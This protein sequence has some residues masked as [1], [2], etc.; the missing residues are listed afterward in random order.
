[1]ADE[2]DAQPMPQVPQPAHT[3]IAG[4]RHIQLTADNIFID[5]EPALT[6]PAELEYARAYLAG[7]LAHLNAG[8]RRR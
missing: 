3:I 2:P 4:D 8:P 1:M 6:T 5:G 7:A